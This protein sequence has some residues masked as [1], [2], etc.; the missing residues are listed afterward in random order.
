MQS[1]V[2][3]ISSSCYAKPQGSLRWQL[4]LLLA[5]SILYESLFPNFGL[6]VIDESW[7]LYAAMRMHDGGVLYDD[8]LWV[9]PPAHVIPGWIAYSL[10]PPGYVLSRYFYAAFD[11]AL[12]VGML[13]LGRR[14]MPSSFAFLGALLVA[15]AA[16]RSHIFQLL[17]GYRYLIFSVLTLLAFSR[18]LRTGDARWM[19]AA[20][21]TAGIALAFRLT[22]AFAV[23]CGVGIAAMAADTHWRRWLKDWTWYA[24]GLLVVAI[25]I[26]VGFASTV[27]LPT[28]W[29][30]VVIHPL[31][32]LQPLSPPD[33]EAIDWSRRESIYRWFVAVQFRTHWFLYAGYVVAL[34]YS[35]VRARI[36][37]KPFEHALL[38][39]IVVWGGIYFIR[40]LGRSDEAHLDSA[41][42]PV[43][44]LFAHLLS[45]CFR[46]S[47][48]ARA[49]RRGLRVF[50][51]TVIVVVTTSL[52][53]YF[54][55]TDLYFDESRR[56]RIV[57]H[58]TRSLGEDIRI[59]SKGRALQVDRVVRMIT[60]RTEPDAQIL[61]MS[62]TP[63]FYLLTA[64]K[65]PGYFDIVMPG[66]F[67]SDEDEIE[68][69]Q[70][71]ET[72]P[73]AAVIW[74]A[75]AFD[76]MPDRAVGKTAPRVSAWV[77]ANYTR[78][79]A[80]QHRWF[81]MFPNKRGGTE[82]KGSRS[83]NADPA[84]AGSAVNEV[85]SPEPAR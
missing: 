65:G 29:H 39:A 1:P 47:W 62:E 68:F 55:G 52:W 25:P 9:F 49:N 28:L 10:D 54:L 26:L 34:G 33:I 74:P 12:A 6:N 50:A 24:A 23:S 15:L 64:R 51:E 53:V 79:K 61:N 56:G 2:S 14:I 71:L 8:V 43:C 41:I 27:G 57:L 21:I 69:I 30:E 46:A 81:V 40:S 38:V 36:A 4:P 78:S 13:F 67:M 31:G 82:G 5:I 20:G 45:V 63:M 16:P 42:P 48:T 22:P 17:F 32:M 59:A 83:D 3:H 66:T 35:W 60:R 70:R 85:V 18:R 7:P 75:R 77:K 84:T 72:S 37:R 76:D 73:P 80:K 58:S 19:L 44:L 11:V